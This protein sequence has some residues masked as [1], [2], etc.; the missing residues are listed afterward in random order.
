MTSLAEAL[1]ARPPRET[2]GTLSAN[3]FGYQRT[4]ALCHLLELHAKDEPYVLLLE[5][6]DDVVVLDHDTDPQSV[7]FFQVKTR[8]NGNWT[9]NKLLKISEP[10]GAKRT[11]PEARLVADPTTEPATPA[12]PSPR[13]ILGKL[14]E[15]CRN[16][17]P[18]VGRLCLVSNVSFKASLADGAIST[19]RNILSLADFSP[20]QLTSIRDAMKAELGIETELPWEKVFLLTTDINIHDHETYGAG[21][22]AAF[23]EARK[24]GARF[25]VQPL[26]RTICSELGRRSTNEWEPTTFEQLCFKKGI[27]R[28]DFEAFLR[29]GDSVLDPE[30][31][32]KEVTNQLR[33]E[34]VSFR[35]ISDIQVAWRKYDLERLDHSNL[36]V[37]MVRKQLN[38]IVGLIHESPKW[39]TLRDMVVEGVHEFNRQFGA[40]IPQ[41]NTTYLKGALLYEFRS[42]RNR[43]LPA[44]DSQPSKGQS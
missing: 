30:D 23:L 24:P 32:L 9:I 42:D 20:D 22:L 39:Y 41:F 5:F 36:A 40:P 38:I 34:S 16:F 27:R 7:D 37:Q 33:H 18:Q 17:S 8:D 6:H 44:S 35:E 11:R 28:S 29:H 43:Q 31:E 1:L 4:W 25:A 21:R 10:S 13:S 12:N 19:K 2:S 3:R 15:H 14:L 26:F